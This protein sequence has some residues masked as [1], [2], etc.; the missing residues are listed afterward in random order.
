MPDK[1]PNNLEEQLLLEQAK[2]GAEVDLFKRIKVL[3]D[4]EAETSPEATETADKELV[5]APVEF[6]FPMLAR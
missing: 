1:T 3:M 5:T 4:M 2:T 6:Y